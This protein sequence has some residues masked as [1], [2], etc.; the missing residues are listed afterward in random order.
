[1]LTS[2][3]Y[4]VPH[5]PTLLVDQHRG[6]HTEM[7]NALAAAGAA[8]AEETP[9]VVV[10]LSARWNTAGPFRVDAGKRHRTITDYA[11]L[12][13]EAR[14]DCTGHPALARALVVAGERAGVHVAAGTRGVDSGATVPLHFLF[15]GRSVR[16]VPLSLPERDPLECRVWGAVL[17]RALEARAERVTFLVGGVL[18]DNQHA[19]SL[20]RDM[21][22]APALDQSVLERLARGEWSALAPRERSVIERARPEAGLRHLEVLRGFLGHDARGIVRCYESGPG[23]GAALI[24]FV[25][26]EGDLEPLPEPVKDATASPPAAPASR[27]K[28]ARG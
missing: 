21:P 14:Y 17:R 10:I 26:A 5:R 12:G 2:R 25:L 27:R 3:A 4:L 6:H 19:W 18:S 16:V 23:V 9:Q 15:P 13:V 11:G 8:L 22:E 20:R 7:L 28:S 1:M 24:E